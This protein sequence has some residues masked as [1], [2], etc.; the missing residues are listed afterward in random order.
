[1]SA[2]IIVMN[3]PDR[4]FRL[5]R[6][7]RPRDVRPN[8]P[9]RVHNCALRGIYPRLTPEARAGTP[10]NH[11]RPGGSAEAPDAVTRKPVNNPRR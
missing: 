8:S 7:G 1:M 11:P 4:R 5:R 10:P 2:E 9:H 6:D 3:N